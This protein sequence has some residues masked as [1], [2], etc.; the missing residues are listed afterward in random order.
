MFNLMETKSISVVD[1]DVVMYI[2]QLSDLEILA[3]MT[4]SFGLGRGRRDIDAVFFLEP[5]SS[6]FFITWCINS[7]SKV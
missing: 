7:C 5:L 1:W 4:D 6:A 2:T 3:R